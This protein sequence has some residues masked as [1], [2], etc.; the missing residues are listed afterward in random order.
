VRPDESPSSERPSVRTAAGIAGALLAAGTDIL[1]GVPGGGSNLDLVGA[2]Q[3]RGGRF[4]LGHGESS[5]AIMAATYGELTGRPGACVVT[6]GPGAASAVNGVAHAF[7]DRIPMVIV[8]DGFTHR[9]GDRVTHQRLDHRALFEPVTKLSLELGPDEAET[10]T[11][12]ALALACSPPQGPVHLDMVGDAQAPPT[13]SAD[14]S[15][16]VGLAERAQG[17]E[18]ITGASEPVVVLGVGARRAAKAV[19]AALKPLRCPILTTYK[20]KGILPESW[21]TAAGLLT[22]A[23]VE[24]P[25]LERA[26]LIVAIGLDAVELIPAPWPY[27][28][29]VL[30]LSE[31][32]R[33]DGYLH[34]EL[35]LVAPLEELLPLLEPLGRLPE[36]SSQPRAFL[37]QALADLDVAVSGLAPHVVVRT[38]RELAPP[39]TVATVDA[40][41]HMLVAMPYWLVEEPGEALISSG[42]ATMGFALPAAISA[43]LVREGTRVICLCGDGGLGMALAELETLGRLRLPVIVIAFN[44]SALSLIEIKQDESQGGPDAVR[45]ATTDFAAIAQGCGLPACRVATADELAA[46]LQAALARE[47]PSLIDTIVDPRGY[48]AILEAIRG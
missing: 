35:E 21:P 45:Y 31:W 23:R 8:T 16:S 25:V 32:P 9:D 42:L 24:A 7:L 1:F 37:E 20:A 13:L 36:P 30:A 19:Q 27:R 26:D 44:D 28:A 33:A 47:G 48:R 43:A 39:G 41:A 4:A 17:A 5:A 3:C 10:I 15:P 12:D 34:P 14:S 38:A 29:P 22:G 18:L 6:R 2:V 40:G 11:E 46:A